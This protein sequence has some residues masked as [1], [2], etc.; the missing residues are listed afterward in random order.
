MFMKGPHE[1]T[2]GGG[3]MGTDPEDDW[4]T[5]EYLR[6][7][8]GLLAKGLNRDAYELL[9]VA[10]RRYPDEPFLLSFHGYLSALLEGKYRN[11]IDACSRAIGLLGKRALHSEEG[12]DERQYAVLYL[13]L[14][15]S[16]LAGGRRKEAYDTLQ[17]GLRYDRNNQGLQD[18]LKKLGI[19]RYVPVPF[20]DRSNV[21]NQLIGKIMRKS[22]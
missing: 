15:R 21:I 13:N 4:S 5:A 1:T 6:V 19:R 18:A 22:A 10:M 3:A 11:G 8:K 14:G 20:L 16:Y 17:K 7:T 2:A 9:Q 12:L